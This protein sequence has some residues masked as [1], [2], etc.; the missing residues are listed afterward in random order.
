MKNK[1]A[2]VTGSSSGIGKSIAIELSKNGFEVVINFSK[3][4]ER[5]EKV[6][7]EILSFGSRAHLFQA[8]ITKE[9]LF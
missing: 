4:K 5:A 7:N 8:D 1:I 6:L 2:L 9:D 3:S